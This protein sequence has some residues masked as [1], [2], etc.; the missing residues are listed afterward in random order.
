MT[1]DAGCAA[2]GDTG[3]VAAG[4]GS[5]DTQYA[6][7]S[8]GGTIIKGLR[9]GANFVWGAG[10]ELAYLDDAL[11]T[12]GKSYQYSNIASC[13]GSINVEY[14]L[15]PELSLGV[16]AVAASGDSSAIDALDGDSADDATLFHSISYAAPSLIFA[17]QL[18]GM[19]SID[20]SVSYKPFPAET[21]GIKGLEAASH[22]YL[23]GKLGTGPVYAANVVSDSSSFV[24]LEEDISCSARI[25]T[26]FGLNATLAAFLPALYPAGGSS[27]AA[28]PFQFA[29]KIGAYLYL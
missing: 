3:L 6:A 24:G 18:G 5:I 4:G 27:A 25:F 22:T 16:F 12:T 11:S 1:P 23:F 20:A 13:A 7:L 19:Y 10:R 29:V 8:I 26:D 15:L 21:V 14:A 28:Y 2:W 9:Y 17:P